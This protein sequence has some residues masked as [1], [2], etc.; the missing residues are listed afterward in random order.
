MA[1][2]SRPTSH[3]M[4]VNAAGAGVPGD[5]GASPLFHGR[6]GTAGFAGFE[7]TASPPVSDRRTPCRQPRMDPPMRQVNTRFFFVLV[8]AAAAFAATLFGVHRLHAR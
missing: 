7:E 2:E 3:A 8:A 4:N 1:Q 6:F 5:T